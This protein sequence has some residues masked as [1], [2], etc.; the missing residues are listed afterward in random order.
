MN[1]NRDLANQIATESGIQVVPIY[2]DSLSSGDG[3]AA[4]YVEF[5]QHNVGEIVKALK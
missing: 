5:M 3:P 2:T 1:V 4:G